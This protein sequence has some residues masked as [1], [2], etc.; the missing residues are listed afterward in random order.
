LPLILGLR[1][2]SE[3]NGVLNMRAGAPTLTFPGSGGFAVK[4]SPGTRHFH[5]ISAASGH[6]ILPCDHFDKV[7]EKGGIP[8]PI[9]VFHSTDVNEERSAGASSSGGAAAE[10]SAAAETTGSEE[11]SVPPPVAP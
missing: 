2:M 5:L 8:R 9:T 4:W 7:Q 11:T 6:L 3:K 10:A 1:S